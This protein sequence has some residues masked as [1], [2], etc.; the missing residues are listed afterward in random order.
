MK[1]LLW[2]AEKQVFI[3]FNVCFPFARVGLPSPQGWV[4][5]ANGWCCRECWT[6]KWH[7]GL[8]LKLPFVSQ[9]NKNMTVSD[10]FTSLSFCKSTTVIP[11]LIQ[12]TTLSIPTQASIT[13]MAAKEVWEQEM[14]SWFPF[15]QYNLYFS[16]S[17]ESVSSLRP[18]MGKKKIKPLSHCHL[19]TKW[20]LSTQCNQAYGKQ[21]YCLYNR[22]KKG[23]LALAFRTLI[24]Y[25]F[26]NRKD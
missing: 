5:M 22:S 6:H 8:T 7:M 25:I 14:P 21:F 20:E 4:K 15:Q 13:Y 11:S 24:C 9:N 16:D 12:N 1:K 26:S 2:N 19:H 10:S 3:I 17:R 18:W 23:H